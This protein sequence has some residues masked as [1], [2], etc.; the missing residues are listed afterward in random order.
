M[1]SQ[2][3]ASITDPLLWIGNTNA[4]VGQ[5]FAFS[6]P[7]APAPHRLCA[8]LTT[9]DLRSHICPSFLCRVP[10]PRAGSTGIWHQIGSAGIRIF[11]PMSCDPP[12]GWGGG[13]ERW[14]WESE[15]WTV[16]IFELPALT[17]WLW[18][19]SKVTLCL[20]RQNTLFARY[21]FCETNSH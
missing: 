4:Q 9:F 11:L 18:R 14:E 8:R 19:S 17:L 5:I 2:T 6:R 1:V 10:Q 7:K 16:V 13:S 20:Y 3:E 21:D 15:G 12:S